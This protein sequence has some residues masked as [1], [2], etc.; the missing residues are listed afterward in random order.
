MFASLR[1][2][3]QSLP[4][5]AAV[6]EV[7]ARDGL[8]AVSQALS[9]ARRAA[10]IRRLLDAG[11]PEAEAGSFVHPGRV[12]QMAGAAQVL[13][14]LQPYA[15]R[16]WV[17]V[18]NRRG[19]E[20]A[21]A[22]GARNLVCMVSATETHSRAN[23]GRTVSQ[24]LADLGAL[25][26]DAHAAGARTRIAV[27]MAWID[28]DEGAVAPERVV[29]LVRELGDAG[30][31]ELTL[32]DTYG[33]ASPRA[34]AGLVEA[35]APDFPP[36]QVGLHLHDTFGVAAANTLAGLAAGV[37]RFDGS[38]GGLGG[39]PF[40]PGARGNADMG[41]LAYLLHSLGV[42]TGID[43]PALARAATECLA[44]LGTAGAAPCPPP[45]C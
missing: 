5:R 13:K 6:V 44:E 39:C 3:L 18:P 28:P 15:E 10:W 29:W 32:C 12:P 26:R 36:T 23:L 25:A 31:R 14:I 19:L 20:E 27:S 43:R 8:Q 11:V 21:L 38:I 9:P 33:G 41:H 35:V 24:V 16:L 42:E 17:L 40:A 45:A 22:A 30:F 34:V 7:S 1:K 2:V 37:R 4:S